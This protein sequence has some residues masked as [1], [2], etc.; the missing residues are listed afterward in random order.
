MSKKVIIA[1]SGGV[2]SSVSAHLLKEKGYNVIGITLKMFPGQEDILEDAENVAKKL[3]IQWYFADYSEHFRNDVISYFI[4][5]YRKGMT[6]NPCCFCN[7]YAK[8]KY[9]F[10]QMQKLEAEKIATGHYARN[11]FDGKHSYIAKAK[12]ANKD[13]S[14]YLCL[15]DEFYINLMKFPLGNVKSKY[16]VRRIAEELKLDVAG[17]KDSQEIC[18]LQGKDYKDYLKEKIPCSKFQKGNF[19]YK[20]EIL[21]SHEGIEFYTTGQRKGLNTGYHKPLYVVKIDPETKNIYLGDFQDIY[22]SGVKIQN[23]NFITDKKFFK[24]DVKLRYRMK[25][26]KCMVERL[27]SDEAVILFDEKQMAPTPGQIAAVYSAVSYT[28]LTLPTK[29]IV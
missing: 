2:D 24:A 27:P 21:K 1:M 19:I 16:E 8:M 12:N 3:G 7:K 5:T 22:F 17:K 28:H 4:N 14:Y 15:L 18:F 10:D 25:S 9:L 23:C 6:P 11:I 29:R 26:A 13:Q 20:G